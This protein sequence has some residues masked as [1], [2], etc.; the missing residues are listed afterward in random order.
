MQVHPTAMQV[1]QSFAS[2]SL[3][4]RP[5][6]WYPQSKEQTTIESRVKHEEQRKKESWRGVSRREEARNGVEK[7]YI[8]GE[9]SSTL[10]FS[11]SIFFRAKFKG[12]LIWCAAVGRDMLS[13]S[14]LFLGFVRVAGSKEPL[15]L[16]K[17][18]AKR[19]SNSMESYL[20]SVR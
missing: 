12:E 17:N 1:I 13:D 5:T 9:R 14:W 18:S 16:A 20:L 6:I 11:F 15:V 19:R 4:N 7:Q 10:G 2:R 8:N 3:I